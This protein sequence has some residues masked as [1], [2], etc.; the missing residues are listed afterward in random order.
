MKS[1][2]DASKKF[3][4]YWIDAWNKIGIQRTGRKRAEIIKFKC[5]VC[6]CMET[7]SIELLDSSIARLFDRG[8]VP[9]I[10]RCWKCLVEH[11]VGGNSSRWKGGRL[12]QLGYYYLN[13]ST[14][15]ND[16]RKFIPKN[17]P[18]KVYQEHRLVVAKKLGRALDKNEVVHHINGIKTD[19]RIENLELI[20]PAHHL[21]ITRMEN[22]WKKRIRDLQEENDLLREKL[23]ELVLD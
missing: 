10:Y 2:W 3:R 8:T 22:D 16:D 9:Y 5:M 21:A 12:L 1:R 15:S 13:V 23:M 17:Y 18:R 4:E 7:A 19:N 20:D 14:L 6:G 11:R